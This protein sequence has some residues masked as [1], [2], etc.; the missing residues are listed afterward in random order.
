M[1]VSIAK[2]HPSKYHTHRMLTF[3]K[4][5]IVFEDQFNLPITQSAE[6]KK[7]IEKLIVNVCYTTFSYVVHLILMVIHYS[8]DTS[9][10]QRGTN[11]IVS[12][13]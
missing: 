11:G 13:L 8:Q 3:N 9:F 5:L 12:H 2:V 1:N 7:K 6:L 10:H 4:V